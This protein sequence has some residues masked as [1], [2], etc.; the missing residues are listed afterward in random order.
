MASA[1]S[2]DLYELTMMAGYYSAGVGDMATFELYVREFPKHRLYLVAAGLD[3]A[4]DYLESLRFQPDEIDY[5]RRQPVLANV[6]ASFF[7]EYLPAFQFSGD[8]WAPEE[9]TPLFPQQPLLRVTAPLMQAQLVET[10]LLAIVG[11]QTTIASK[12]AR[13]VEVAGGRPVVEFGGRRAHGTEA[14]MYAARAAY[15]AGCAST[16]NV[17]AGMRFDIPVSG[18]MA[19]SWVMTFADEME[20]FR[21]FFQ[22]YGDRSVFL[23]DTYDT[24]ASARKIVA[25][26]LRPA[27]VRLDSGN[28]VELSRKVRH[29]LDAGGLKKTGIFVSGDLDEYKIASFLAQGA[30]LNGFGVGTALST[31]RDA[32]ALGGIYKLVEVE[33]HGELVPTMKLSPGKHSLPGRK[34]VWRIF[35]RHKAAGDV[36]GLS[37]ETGPHGA[38]PLLQR[39]MGGGRRLVPRRALGEVRERCLKLVGQLPADLRG[40]AEVSAYPVVVSRA[41]EALAQRVNDRLDRP[42]A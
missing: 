10:A 27:A 36:L 8:I 13:I 2:T 22:L 18:T 23:I 1:L 15:I 30:P 21:A 33:R 11:F 31:S 14:A 26:G 5:L 39:V 37:D 34:Q 41:L 42:Q 7:D 6:P 20:A 24:L 9:G 4:I 3:Q 25:S 28:I 16:S 32:P 35:E 17:E 19:H 12:A 40:L 38:T 29:I